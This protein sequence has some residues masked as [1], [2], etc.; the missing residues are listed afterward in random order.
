MKNYS[1]VKIMKL[2]WESY[3]QTTL[4]VMVILLAAYGLYSFSEYLHKEKLFECKKIE[5]ILQ[6]ESI[7]IPGDGCLIKKDGLLIHYM[8]LEK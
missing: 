8:R 7:F 1:R 4:I 3:I 5:E 2:D 6:L